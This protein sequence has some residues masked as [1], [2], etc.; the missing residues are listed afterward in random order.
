MVQQ[1]ESV[2]LNDYLEKTYR[3]HLQWKHV[4]IGLVGTP[5]ELK[6]YSSLRRWV[7]AVVLDDREIVLI[8]AK[9]VPDP[10]AVGQL[11]YYKTIFSSTPEF[12]EF[13]N[14]PIRLELLVPTEDQQLRAYC[15]QRGIKFVVW[16]ISTQKPL[17]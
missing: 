2:L 17:S 6:F 1:S 15:E 16:T 12:S 4:R 7:D 14:Y 13:A 8:E 10:R 5:D 11:E 9:L 3:K